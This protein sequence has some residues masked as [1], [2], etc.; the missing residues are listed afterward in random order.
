MLKKKF[1]SA[2]RT[3]PSASAPGP[4]SAS[5]AV[6]ATQPSVVATSSAL[7]RRP[8]VGVRADQRA[9]DHDG[10]VRHRQRRRPRERRPRGVARDHR[11]EVGVE[12]RGDDDRRV[13]GVREVVHRPRHH[14]A[15]AHAEGEEWCRSGAWRWRSGVHRPSQSH[16]RTLS[17]RHARDDRAEGAGGPAAGPARR[18]GAAAPPS[19]R[20]EPGRAAADAEA[21]AGRVARA[22]AAPRRAAV[23]ARPAARRRHRLHPR[24][25]ADRTSGSS[26]W[27]LV[28][29][30]RDGEILLE[31]SER[32]ARIADRDHGLA[33]S[34]SP[35]PRRSTPTRSPTSRPT[36]P[37]RSSRTSSQSLPR[38]GARAAARRDVLPG[39]RG[40][41]ADGLRRGLG[42]RGRHAGGG[43]RATCA[44]STSC[45]TTPT[46]CS[47][48]TASSEL[49]GTLPL[50][51][52][53][54]HRSRARGR[55]R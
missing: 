25:A 28:K 10:G 48:S 44:A 26:V 7:F 18:A 34:W 36:C 16:G 55:A 20:R 30:E 42:A 9:G 32:G 53:D 33:R 40:R 38:R 1:E 15:R 3:Q 5:A 37:T 23:E 19:H 31:V 17:Y 52:P 46:S 24:G 39:G 13:A 35:R 54:R 47:S 8:L 50:A 22:Q 29:A 6:N 49:K 51:T 14:L 4:T 45:P 43:D 11:D 21:R 2:T 27:D 41:R 12:D